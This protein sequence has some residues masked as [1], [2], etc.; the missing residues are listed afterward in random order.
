MKK[1][2]KKKKK[3]GQVRKTSICEE[4]EQKSYQNAVINFPR[5]A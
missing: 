2:K 1:K 4:K 5:V 3:K